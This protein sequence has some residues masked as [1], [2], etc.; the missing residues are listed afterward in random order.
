MNEYDLLPQLFETTIR[1]FITPQARVEGFTEL[2][3]GQHEVGWS[4]AVI[5]RYEVQIAGALPVRLITKTM[6]LIERRV[7]EW[8]SQQGQT[9]IP[10]AHTLDLETDAPVVTCLQDLGQAK[11]GLPGGTTLA[12]SSSEI[13]SAVATAWAAIH[14]GNLGRVDKLAWLP[15][16]DPDYVNQVFIPDFFHAYWYGK[17][18]ADADFA[19]EFAQ[20]TTRLERA[21]DRFAAAIK[22]LWQD[23]CSLTLTHGEAHGE[24]ILIHEQRPYFIDW[25]T[26]RYGPF[27]L[28]LVLYFTP[29]NVHLYREALAEQGVSIGT[30]EFLDAYH[31]ARR[32]VGFKWLCSGIWQW[33]KGPTIENGRRL[34]LMLRWA[35]DGEAP[36]PPFLI[37]DAFWTRLLAA[38]ERPQAIA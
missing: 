32:Y 26:A 27:Y 38:H 17:L 4:G 19:R 31:E 36:E 9:N 7:M 29:H 23:G 24:H 15:R 1:R 6:P 30:A 10:F 33:G 25:A 20:Y 28:D 3:L 14:I 8:L 37:S 5:R 35:I 16:F 22:A 21:A 18:E 12:R 34:L 13:D 2:P 11:V